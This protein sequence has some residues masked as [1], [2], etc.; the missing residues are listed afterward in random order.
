M[1]LNLMMKCTNSVSPPIL[2]NWILFTI[3]AEANK[4]LQNIFL[5]KIKIPANNCEFNADILKEKCRPM[6]SGSN[7]ALLLAGH[8]FTRETK[9]QEWEG[10]EKEPPSIYF[11]KQPVDEGDKYRL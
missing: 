8:V 7:V 5:K 11:Q 2:E 1:Y 6:E 4:T 10:G 3:K 9:E